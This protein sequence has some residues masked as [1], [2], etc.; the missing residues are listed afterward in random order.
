M[1]EKM[2]CEISENG[3]S[4]FSVTIKVGA[5]S[6]AGDEPEHLGGK[7]TGPAPF[8]LLASSLGA[9][10]AM[11]VRWYAREQKWPLEHVSVT[12]THEK[13]DVDG[14]RVDVFTKI[15]NFKGAS[16]SAEQRQKLIDVAAKCPVQ[17]AMNGSAKIETTESAPT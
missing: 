13:T 11:T 12:V 5:H 8:Q 2:H 14:R 6:L 7:S 16:L 15:L 9:C 17:R 10:S 1:N 3:D 4:P